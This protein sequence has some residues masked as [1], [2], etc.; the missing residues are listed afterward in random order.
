[1]GSYPYVQDEIP[2]RIDKPP[3]DGK[4]KS[5]GPEIFFPHT[6]RDDSENFKAN[7]VEARDN[8]K[9][10]IELCNECDRIKE[11]FAYS[12]YHEMYGIWAGTTERQRKTLRR[13]MKIKLIPREPIIM[14]PGMNLK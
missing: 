5:V 13:R 4:C 8:T 3:L 9:Q 11:C 1:M 12:I 7:Y 10:A 2:T 14:I 6:E